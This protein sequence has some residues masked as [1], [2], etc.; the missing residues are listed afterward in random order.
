[1]KISLI[2]ISG[3]FAIAAHASDKFM[4][5]PDNVMSAKGVVT[6]SVP[7]IKD[8]GGKYDLAMNVHN[9]ESDKGIIIFLSDM[10]CQRGTLAGSLKHT[11]FNTGERT[12]DFK[13]GQSKDFKLVC[14]VEGKTSGDFKLTVSKVYDNPSLDGKTVGKIIAKDL[15]WTQSDRKE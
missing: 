4:P 9:D 10:G 6:I 15:S 13:P 3:L 12:I 8:K 1:M 2:L 7:W 5:G 11:F 14:K